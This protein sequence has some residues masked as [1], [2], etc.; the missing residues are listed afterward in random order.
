MAQYDLP[1]DELEAYAP[2]ITEPADLDDFW[3]R[4]LRE[5]DAVDVDARFTEV[6]NDLALITTYDVSFRG[7]GGDVVRGWLHVPAGAEHPLPAVV[8]YLGYNGGRGLAHHRTTYALAGYA[9]FVMDTRG[10]GWISP[11]ATPDPH[12]SPLSNAVPGK[13]T[14]GILDPERYYYRRVYV[15]AVRAIAAAA[16]S[17]HVDPTRIVVAGA[18]QGGGL[19]LAA[20]SLTDVPVGALID[21]PFLCHFRRAITVSDRDPYREIARYLSVNRDHTERVMHTLSYVDG[22]ALAARATAPALFSVAL[23]DATCP[24]STVYAAYNRYGGAKSMAVYPFNDHEGGQEFHQVEK[25]RW[26]A[27]LFA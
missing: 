4:T 1:L 11:G 19:A 23:M 18:S 9:H 26:L 16:E 17:A 3:R 15:D 13:M 27:R 6:D 12:H 7:F 14:D 10:Q 25:Y 22:A 5:A 21:V 8:D 2:A 20:A 24:P